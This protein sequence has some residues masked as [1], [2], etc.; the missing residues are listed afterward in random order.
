MSDLLRFEIVS[1]YLLT[2]T[3]LFENE[4]FRWNCLNEAEFTLASRFTLASQFVNKSNVDL[5]SKKF[6]FS[7]LHIIFEH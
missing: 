3:I 2:H 4:K 7:N 1:A 6:N 5:R